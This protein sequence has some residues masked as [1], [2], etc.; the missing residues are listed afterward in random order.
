M[1]FWYAVVLLEFKY[2]NE[3]RIRCRKISSMAVSSLSSALITPRLTSLTR[4]MTGTRVASLILNFL[5]NMHFQLS[6]NL[7]CKA[8]TYWPGDVHQY[9]YYCVNFF[10]TYELP[11]A[12]LLQERHLGV[13]YVQISSKTY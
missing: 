10:Y 4:H 8:T 9:L 7:F 2:R 6:G 3:E 12:F 13:H 1:R 5:S 11:L